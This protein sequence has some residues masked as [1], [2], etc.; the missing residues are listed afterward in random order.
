M[1]THVSSCFISWIH[2]LV[3]QVSKRQSRRLQLHCQISKVHSCGVLN[4]NSY[5]LHC[6][7]TMNIFWSFA[8]AVQVYLDTICH[9]WTGHSLYCIL[10]IHDCISIMCVYDLKCTNL[11][12]IFPCARRYQFP[13]KSQ[14]QAGNQVKDFCCTIAKQPLSQAVTGHPQKLAGGT[15]T[16]PHAQWDHSIASPRRAVPG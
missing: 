12:L 13:C 9:L 11:V 3:D 8:V 10:Y 15:C 1:D 5:V 2:P 16:C 7:S 6:S 4:G 14:G